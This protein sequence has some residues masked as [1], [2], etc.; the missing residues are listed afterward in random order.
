MET[1]FKQLV[2]K[3]NMTLTSLAKYFNVSR[4]HLTNIANGSPAGRQLAKRIM[5]KHII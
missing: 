5:E 1:R 3:R 2:R 4:V